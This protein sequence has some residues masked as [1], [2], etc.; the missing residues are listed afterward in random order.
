M[1]RNKLLI[2]NVDDDEAGKYA[3]NRQLQQAGYE[4]VPASDGK[5]GLELAVNQKPDL[6]LLD[7][8]LPDID[9]FEVCRRVRENPEIAH[10]PI[11]QM[12][13][14]YI[15]TSS[16]VKGLETGADAYLTEPVEPAILLA[17][18]NSVLRMRRAEQSVRTSALRW[19]TTLDAIHQ[20]VALLDEDGRVIQA[21]QAFHSIAGHE[22]DKIGAIT[23]SPFAKVKATA[24][25]QSEEMTDQSRILVVTMDPVRGEDHAFAGAVCTVTD[26]T[27]RK[28][29]DQKMLH[30]A[31]LESIG[32]LAGG[33]AHDF[34]NLLT[35]ILGNASLLM[36]T[37]DVSSAE[38]PIALEIMKAS[39]SAAD[40]TRQI[41]A[42]SGR[43]RFVMRAVD[44]S[45]LAM[46]NRP[47]V[48]RF[49]PSRLELILDL[50]PDLP[51]IQA[52]S[53]QM[54]QLIMNLIINAAEAFEENG[55]GE[56]TV[57]TSVEH[58]NEAFFLPGEKIEP[59]EYVSLTVRDT[60]IGMDEATQTRIFDP[61]FTTKFAGRGLGL[62]AVHG[63]LRGHSGL[64]RL[65][66]APGKGTTF[67]LYF[68]A[69][70]TAP[71]KA[72]AIRKERNGK[73]SGTVLVVDDE[74]TVRNFATTAL[75]GMGFHVLA[76][77][78]GA[79]AVDIFEKD[80][81]IL[82]LVLLDLTLPVM[83][84]EETFDRLCEINAKVPVLLSSGFHQ[85]EALERFRARG[86]A[87]FLGKPYTAQQLAQAVDAALNGQAALKL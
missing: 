1:I 30:T 42:Y 24:S 82:G 78:N 45:A 70:K 40:L 86:I 79:A 4:V 60:G 32:I 36:E 50:A 18:I 35:G 62:S 47:F 3:V 34:N 59:G 37:L 14:S 75:E 43:G 58:I 39:E 7:V 68:P 61:F 2:L 67:R 49:I 16:R 25:H 17:T 6:I 10:T 73:R 77:D 13:A 81:G 66:S 21:N 22:S 20:G 84:A 56:I 87:G 76:T 9:G 57:T 38:R 85:G 80:H 71:K 52:D 54:Q 83:T 48:R 12:S 44:L 27:E 55:K 46:E 11:I 31:K 74:L 33:I 5:S 63:I 65:E 26:I 69:D 19:Q 41:L 8:R 15:D 28:N 53:A 29:F 72:P 51:F 23:A 64:L